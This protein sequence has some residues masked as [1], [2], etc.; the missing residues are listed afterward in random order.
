MGDSFCEL[1]IASTPD[2]SEAD[3]VSVGQKPLGWQNPPREFLDVSSEPNTTIAS[4]S[5]IQSGR[6]WVSSSGRISFGNARTKVSTSGSPS[7]GNFIQFVAP[8]ITPRMRLCNAACGVFP[9]TI[10]R[11]GLSG[12]ARQCWFP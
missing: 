6:R 5:S 8:T 9:L 10:C 2:Q 3:L 7:C 12:T 11:M 1:R 4:A